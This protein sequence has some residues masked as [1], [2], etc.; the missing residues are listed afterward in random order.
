MRAT[1]ERTASEVDP[2]S[3]MATSIH[4]HHILELAVAAAE[5]TIR[6]RTAHPQR[7]GPA[8]ADVVFEEVEGYVFRGDA[9]GTILFD[10]EVV[11]AIS[12]YRERG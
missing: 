1:V 3:S 5:R 12:L 7:T 6:L 9:L 11:D 8:F 2:Q 4:D 10:I